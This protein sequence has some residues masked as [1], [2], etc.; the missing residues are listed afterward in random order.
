[1][2]YLNG[3]Q[4]AEG[5]TARSGLKQILKFG[6]NAVIGTDEETIWDQGG[7]YA[8]PTSAIVMKC[9]SSNTG[10]TST[11]ISV[12]GLDENYNELTESI[13]LNGQTAVN[14]TNSFIRVNRV[15]VTDTA[16]SG[17]VYVGTGTVTSGVPATKYAKIVAGENQTEMAVWTVPSGYTGYIYK[18]QASGGSTASNKYATLKLKV[19]PS[20]G[21][22]RTQTTMVVQQNSAEF[23]LDVPII[24]TEK[25]DIEIRATASSGTEAVTA[26]MFIVYVKN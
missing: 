22:F 23:S 8:Y 11:V 10:D 5:K 25:S 26:N 14:T 17:D 15:F 3:I 20:G 12:S 19:K 4:I 2:S 24:A 6:H 16:P 7:L 1:M 18:L 13:T 21:V 9:S